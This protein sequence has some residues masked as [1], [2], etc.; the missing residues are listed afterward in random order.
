MRP[1]DFTDLVMV[2]DIIPSDF[3]PFRTISPSIT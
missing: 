2:D 3:S 1:L